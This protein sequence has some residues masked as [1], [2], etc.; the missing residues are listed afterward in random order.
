[1]KDFITVTIVGNLSIKI[2]D[3]NFILQ[4]SIL[5]YQSTNVTGVTRVTRAAAGQQLTRVDPPTRDPY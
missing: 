4:E 5:A 2:I 1:M 3:Y